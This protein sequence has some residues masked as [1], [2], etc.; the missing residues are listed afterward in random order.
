[1]EAT[2]VGTAQYIFMSMNAC[3]MVSD[4]ITAQVFEEETLTIIPDSTI[5]LCSPADTVC[6][7]V[8]FSAPECIVWTDI[9]GNELGT[10]AELCVLPPLGT[11][12]Y[13]ASVPGLDCITA[14]TAT[15][16]VSDD[17]PPPMLPDT[18]LKVCVGDTIKYET[19][20][21]P[22]SYQWKD[23][24][25]NV[26]ASDTSL[27]VEATTV[28]TAQYIFMSMNACGMVSDTITAQVF[29]EETLTIIPDST[30]MLCS[31]AD[32]VCLTVN[33]SAPECIVWTDINGNELGTGAELCVLP[34]LGTSQYIASVPGLDCITA[35]TATIMVSDDMPPPMLPDT[36]LKVCVGDTI[37]YETPDYPFS[38]QWKDINGN[39]LASDTSL[40]V[41]ATTV[42]TVQYIFMS[43]NACGMVNDTIT[44]QVFED[45]ALEIIPDSTITLC[46]PADTV[47]LTVNF[48]APE[49]IVWTDINGN[50]LG[51]GAELCVLPPLGTSQYIASVPGLDCIM[52]DTAIIRVDTIPPPPPFEGEDFNLCLGDTL[53]L[54]PDDY[55]ADFEWIDQD[56][57]VISANDTLCFVPEMTGD[58]TFVFEAE[59]GCGMATYNVGIHTFDSTKIE[60]LPDTIIYLCAPV[61]STVCLEVLNEGLEDEVVWTN[62]NGDTIGMGGLLCVVPP[63]GINSYIASVPGLDCIEADTAMIIVIPENL[64]IDLVIDNASICEG[65]LAELSVDVSPPWTGHN[66]QWF[67]D[68]MLI[69]MGTDTIVVSPP[70]GDYV[71]TAVVSNICTVDSVSANL[72]V[73]SLNV[74]ISATLDTICAGEVTT[75]QVDGCEDCTY[76]WSPVGTLDNPNESVTDASPDVTTIYTVI[77]SDGVCTDTLE[78][79]IVVLPE[80]QCSCPEMFFVATGF[81]PDGDGTNDFAC[82]RSEFLNSYDKIIFMVFNRWGEEMERVEWER[83]SPDDQ[84]GYLD[85]CWD[86]YHRGELLPPDVYGYYIE[87]TCPDG[88]V[89]EDR[90]NITLLR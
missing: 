76:E 28:G 13:I 53:K 69:D 2:T 73:Q 20:D 50:E 61:D 8:N 3:G 45:S 19:P 82:L 15:I 1:V 22:F 26:L 64:D 7:T 59:N 17:M 49:C 18:L 74:E 58:T 84:P 86:G 63:V 23:I 70:A 57:T 66:T 46:S 67:E 90:G 27:C 78:I 40:C 11:S 10:G 39:V 56:G 43:M 51:T 81:T 38:Y 41:E 52:A 89:I 65:G 31:P 5:M 36:L 24:N 47:C 44:A 34:P 87:L 37:K 85:F 4:T 62:L 54:F 68:G 6:L 79:T 72:R 75:L 80:E 32:T 21:Y 12:Q 14:D 83:Q 29:E 48:S 88:K 55:P 35:D 77:V 60:I 71:Y 9:N 33:F 30:I 25:G 42:G 16:I